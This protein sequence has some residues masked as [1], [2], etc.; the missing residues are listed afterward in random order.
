M[1]K[2]ILVT[3][4][5]LSMAFTAG[6]LAQSPSASAV[7]GSNGLGSMTCGDFSH[8]SAADR[9]QL[10]RTAS[11][12][13]VGSGLSSITITPK[14]ND[15]RLHEGDSGSVVG[16]PLSAGALISACEAA[17]PSTSLSSAYTFANTGGNV[18]YF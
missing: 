14:F 10:V 5:A 4:L 3:A 2:Q 8:L 7:L 17:S 16:T 9:Q 18:R 15:G 12:G 6:A 1:N 13:T 11:A